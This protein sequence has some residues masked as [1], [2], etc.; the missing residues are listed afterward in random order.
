VKTIGLIHGMSSVATADFHQRI[1]ARVNEL[2][3]GHEQA[4][5]LIASVNFAIIERCVRTEA[6]E[7]M[8]EYLAAKG[9]SLERR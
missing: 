6:W 5:L 1:N 2:L 7:E 4:E 3:G 9:R 8:G